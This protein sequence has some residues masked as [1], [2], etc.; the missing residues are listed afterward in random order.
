MRCFLELDATS[1]ASSGVRQRS[2]EP[3]MVAIRIFDLYAACVP[4]SNEA[5]RYFGGDAHPTQ[6]RFLAL[7]AVTGKIIDTT[8][9]EEV[10]RLVKAALASDASV[11]SPAP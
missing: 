5:S 9:A 10:H 11:L 7:D 4:V 3:L 8:L 6:L 2:S 1:G